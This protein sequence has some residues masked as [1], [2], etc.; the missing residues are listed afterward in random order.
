M[1]V[2]IVNRSVYTLLQRVSLGLAFRTHILSL[3]PS[4]RE[5]KWEGGVG[6][7]FFFVEAI[8]P[9]GTCQFMAR[10]TV[11]VQGGCEAANF[12]QDGCA[13]SS[14]RTETLPSVQK[15]FR[16]TCKRVVLP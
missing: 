9:K 6:A 15:A 8:A 1:P 5:K 14:V 13:I 12:V 3:F 11:G 2:F 4:R 16:L 7:L 10:L